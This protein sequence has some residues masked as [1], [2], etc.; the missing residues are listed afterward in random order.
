MPVVIYNQPSKDN[1]IEILTFP[2]N[3]FVGFFLESLVIPGH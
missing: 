1:P 2:S 3:S